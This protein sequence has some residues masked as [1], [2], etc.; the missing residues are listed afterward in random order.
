M[1]KLV[2]IEI[3]DLETVETEYPLET[4][5]TSWLTD[6]GYAVAHVEVVEP[7]VYHVTRYLRQMA[8]REVSE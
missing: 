5:I 4:E 2:I 8:K 7:T 3:D 1:S 6:L